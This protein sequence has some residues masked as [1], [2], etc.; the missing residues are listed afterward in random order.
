ML[1]GCLCLDTQ[2]VFRC[3]VRRD[4]DKIATPG[5]RGEKTFCSCSVNHPMI[6]SENIGD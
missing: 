5:L 1:Y 6:P 3:V 4:S 2:G